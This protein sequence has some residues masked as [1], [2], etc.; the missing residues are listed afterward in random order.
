MVRWYNFDHLMCKIH[1]QN[2]LLVLKRVL[3]RWSNMTIF[4]MKMFNSVIVK[5]NRKLLT[6]DRKCTAEGTIPITW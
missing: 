6:I 2:K 5:K 3:Y 4:Y 1:E